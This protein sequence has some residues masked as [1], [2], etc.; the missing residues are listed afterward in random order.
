MEHMDQQN[1][2]IT[3]ISFILNFLKSYKTLKYKLE[4]NI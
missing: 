3:F 1:N 4:L 2:F